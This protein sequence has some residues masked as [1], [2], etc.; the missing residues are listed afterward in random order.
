MASFVL[1]SYFRSSASYRVRIALNLK[2]I[3]YEYRAVHL[4]NNGGEQHREDYRKLNPSQQVPTLIHDGK[5]IGQS[6]AIIE[7]LEQ[8]KPEP[9]LYPAEAHPRALVRQ[10]CEII[11]SGVQPLM[12]LSVLQEL[13]KRYGADQNQKNEWVSHWIDLNLQTLEAFFKTHAGDYC[14]GNQVTAADCFLIPQLAGADR[15]HVSIAPYPTLSRIRKSCANLE[16]FKKAAADV[17]PDT[18]K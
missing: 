10:A 8:I 14:F 9:R 4:L 16:P 11:N 17:Q 18:P 7:Y 6:V 15:Y 2:D 13:E 1:Y 3:T 12:N 5:V